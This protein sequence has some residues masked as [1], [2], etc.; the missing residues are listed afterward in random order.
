[1]L[2]VAEAEQ[3]VLG[4]TPLAPV[5]S[6]DLDRAHGD[7]LREAV[8]ADR[9]FPPYHR[10]AMDGIA[11]AYAAWVQ[12]AR[13]FPVQGIQRAGEPAQALREKSHCLEVMTGAVLP[14]GT[15][16]VVPVEEL[17]LAEGKARL[18]D[19]LALQR[20]QNVHALGSDRPAGAELL[21]AGTLLFGPHCAVAAAVGMA[22]VR[23]AARPRITLISTG[24]EV[25]AVDA[26]PLPHQVRRSNP[27]VLRAALGRAGFYDVTAQHVPDDPGTLAR[28]L[29][30]ALRDSR[31][32]LITGG[33]SEGRFDHVPDVLAELGVVAQFHK[34]SQRPG[35]PLWFGVGREGQ[36]VFGLPGNPVSTAVC[37]YRYVLPALLAHLGAVLCDADS[38]PRAVLTADVTFRKPMTLFQPVRICEDKAGLRLATPVPMNGSGDLA[39]LAASDGFLEI[40]P[41]TPMAAGSAHPLWRWNDP[42]CIVRQP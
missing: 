7:V 5:V 16:C 31:F 40:S 38:R 11:I 28:T 26:V 8:V 24:D 18:V 2:T 36:L 25:V 34:V 3:Q 29:T 35:K 4:A 20:M 32:I 30:A 37:L 33:V 39:G 42:C 27:A 6:R 10:V 22:Q 23:V 14:E 15:D 17:T 41:G 12:G 1:M 21:S 19:S 13:V 9:P